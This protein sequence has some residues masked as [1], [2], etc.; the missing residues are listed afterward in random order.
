M[1]NLAVTNE[2]YFEFLNLMENQNSTLEDFSEALRFNP[3]LVETILNIV[4]SAFFG[5]PDRIDN[6]NSALTL[7]GIGQIYEIVLSSF[8]AQ[9]FEMS[10][11][12][13]HLLH[14]THI[15]PQSLCA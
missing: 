10:E 11:K 6:I 4:N 5:F 8:E 9:A 13:G 2:I 1:N 14:T 7:L 15:P 3:I 12:P